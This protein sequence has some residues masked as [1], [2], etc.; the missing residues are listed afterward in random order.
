MLKK[1]IKIVW[2]YGFFCKKNATPVVNGCSNR[3]TRGKTTCTF[4]VNLNLNVRH[5]IKKSCTMQSHINH[6]TKS[7]SDNVIIQNF[8]S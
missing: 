4:V 7:N 5:N 8:N 2:Y 3:F 1:Q 6:T